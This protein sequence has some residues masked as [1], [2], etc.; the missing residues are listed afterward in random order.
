MP[1]QSEKPIAFA[2]R[3][4]TKAECNYSHLDKEELSLIY[5]ISS[6]L[7]HGGKFMLV[8][9]QLTILNPRKGIPSL[10]QKGIPSLAAA[11]LQ[12]WTLILASYQYEIEFQI[13]DKQLC[14][15]CV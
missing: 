7:V 2:S 8:T 15:R 11:S 4:W 13:T 9:D 12:R 1:D 6:V 3:T 5:E 10:L 14:R